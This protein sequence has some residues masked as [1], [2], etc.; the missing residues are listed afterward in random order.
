MC[1][2]LVLCLNQT[3]I[4][5]DLNLVANCFQNE[6]KKKGEYLFDFRPNFFVFP[7]QKQ[8]LAC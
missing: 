5:S 3:A 2:I 6:Q 7:V 8:S 1:Y 4:V